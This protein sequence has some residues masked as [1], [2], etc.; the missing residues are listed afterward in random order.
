MPIRG[1]RTGQPVATFP[2]PRVFDATSA[3]WADKQLLSR[4]PIGVATRATRGLTPRAALVLQAYFAKF[5]ADSDGVLTP[6][7]IR[8]LLA[9]LADVEEK[10]LHR[11]SDA[12]G[13][14]S[15]ANRD[16]RGI[17]RAP[18]RPG[19][20]IGVRGSARPRSAASQRPSSSASRSRS[21]PLSAMGGNTRREPARP[22]RTHVSLPSKTRLTVVRFLAFCAHKAANEPQFM[23]KVFDLGGITLNLEPRDETMSR[24]LRQR[25]QSH[26][27]GLDGPVQDTTEATVSSTLKATLFSR[28]RKRKGAALKEG[29]DLCRAAAEEEVPAGDDAGNLLVWLGIR[30]TRDAG[31]R[32]GVESRAS[33]HARPSSA[34]PGTTRPHSAMEPRHMSRRPGGAGAPPAPVGVPGRRQSASAAVD[35][36]YAARGERPPR[37]TSAFP[38]QSRT[39]P[40]L[41]DDPGERSTYVPGD[42]GRRHEPR[43]RPQSALATGIPSD[44][45]DRYGGEHPSRRRPSSSSRES[46]D[47]ASKRRGRP[48]RPQSAPRQMVRHSAPTKTV[49]W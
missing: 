14:D 44:E 27:G 30:P 42:S 38:S 11:F 31:S 26:G 48:L 21:R 19:T 7:E 39:R 43:R 5:D 1:S 9:E 13:E 16:S 35:A 34:K 20:A 10:T 33:G 2:K 36:V 17:S 32:S 12:G 47:A 22:R 41:R 18:G 45:R 28:Q 24:A 3:E 40:S 8:Q 37:P 15:V 46:G 29:A 23:S 25:S 6:S 4:A 49:D